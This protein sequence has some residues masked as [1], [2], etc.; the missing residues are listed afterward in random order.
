MACYLANTW[1]APHIFFIGFV[2]AHVALHTTSGLPMHHQPPSIHGHTP[3]LSTETSPHTPSCHT[4]GWAYHLYGVHPEM[5]GAG[6][7][8]LLHWERALWR[9]GGRG[10]GLKCV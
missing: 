7:G 3:Q 1:G 10:G 2:K 9:N 6:P 8:L 4:H 5:L